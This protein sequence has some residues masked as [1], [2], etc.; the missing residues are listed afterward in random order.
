MEFSIYPTGT[1]VTINNLD[2]KQPSLQGTITQVNLRIEGITY[3][4]SYWVDK[5]YKTVTLAESQ[6]IVYSTSI[7]KITIGYK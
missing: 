7:K 2:T 3:E 6:F 4:I 5:S 1:M